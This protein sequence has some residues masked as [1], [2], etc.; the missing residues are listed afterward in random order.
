MAE[1]NEIGKQGE[2]VAVNYLLKNG[3]EIIERNYQARKAEI[4]IIARKGDW[5][6]VVEVKT[7]SSIDFGNPEDFVDKKKIKTPNDF[8]PLIK[9]YYPTE[10]FLKKNQRKLM[11]SIL[12]DM[13]N[14]KAFRLGVIE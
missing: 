13:T 7:R 1:H 4:D 9:R 8:V 12:D 3:Y 6:I 14:N 10:K 2:E 5:L 11:Q